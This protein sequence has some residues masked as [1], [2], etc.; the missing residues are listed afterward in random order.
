VGPLLALGLS[1]SLGR[2]K[3]LLFAAVLFGVSAVGTA[4]CRNIVAFNVL[5]VL[6]GVGVGLSSIVSPMYIAEISP[7]AIRGRLV[8]INNLAIVGGSFAAILVSFAVSQAEL[9]EGWRWM[10]GSQALPVLAFM[11]GLAFAPNSPRWLAGKGRDA[12]ALEVLARIQGSGKAALEMRQI[13]ESLNEESGRFSEL[14]RPGIRLSLLVAVGLGIF[15]Q[16]TGSSVL[17]AN[18]P[19]V[20]QKAGF[21]KESQAIGQSV[22]LMVWNILAT[23]MGMWLVERCGRRPLLLGGLTGMALGLVATGMVFQFDI[24]GAYVLIV[25]FVGIG[26]YVMSL[27]PLTWLLMSELFPTRLRGKAMSVAGMALWTACYGGLQTFPPLRDWFER[28]WG[29]IA[30]VFYL[31]AAVCAVAFLFSWRLVPETKGKTLEEISRVCPAE[32]GRSG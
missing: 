16:A 7:A 4:F 21:A 10:F 5:R 17:F 14:F 31:Y 8:T 26:M 13:R 6:G 25:M 24:S 23:L 12:E 30:G 20:F 9:E 29:S 22:I 2:K 18:A 19:I 15:Q 3:T 28:R 32:S 1:D 11:I 27:A